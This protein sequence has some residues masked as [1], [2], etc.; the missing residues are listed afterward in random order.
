MD[1]ETLIE[2]CINLVAVH[3]RPFEMMEDEGFQMI[4]DPIIKAIDKNSAINSKN[5]KVLT[6]TYAEQRRKEISTLLRGK[7]VS[8]KFDCCT[9]LDRSILGLNVQYIENG[10]LTLRTLGMSEIYERHTGQN[11]KDKVIEILASY[12]IKREQ[13]LSITTDNGSNMITAVAAMNKNS[14]DSEEES[15]TSEEI[16]EEDLIYKQMLQD[17]EYVNKIEEEFKN[18]DVE[19]FRCAAHTLQLAVLDALKL[20]SVERLINRVREL[21]KILKNQTYMIILR[22]EKRKKPIL[23]CKTSP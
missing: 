8:V 9:R 5:V 6:T 16:D 10:K 13:I 21:M 12:E 4:V 22:R 14:I 18:E 7:L 19:G 11:I 1:E 2:A 20:G 23:D 17:E 15:S 3:G